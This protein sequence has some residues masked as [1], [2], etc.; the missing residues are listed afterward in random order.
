M[1]RLVHVARS[2]IFGQRALDDLPNL[3]R[4]CHIWICLI[5]RVVRIV[6]PMKSRRK[7]SDAFLFRGDEQPSIF[8]DIETRLC[9]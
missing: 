1:A 7:D 5:G 9:C 3:V 2:N 6:H 4:D 8:G